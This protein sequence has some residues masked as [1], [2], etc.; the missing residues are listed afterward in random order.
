MKKYIIGGV[1]VI[2]GVIGAARLAAYAQSAAFS[3]GSGTSPVI[4]TISP[5]GDVL[6]RGT[7]ESVTADTLTI[8]SWGGVWTV[9]TS[10]VT[11]VI[12]PTNT[13]A[14][15]KV[16]D[17]AG[18]RGDMAHD[19]SFTIEAKTVRAWGHRTDSDKDGLPN[20]QDNDDDNDGKH[21]SDDLKPFDHDDDGI[22]DDQDSDDDNDLIDDDKDEDPLDHDND[23]IDDAQ[24]END[25]GADDSEDVADEADTD[26]D[27]ASSDS[28]DS[29][30]EE[31]SSESDN[32]GNSSGSGNSGS[33]NDSGS[34]D[35]DE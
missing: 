34:D 13:L 14:D 12:G 22:T 23:D 1:I 16:G 35:D 30:D 31:D 10:P 17:I 7:I 27:D 8:K 33:G 21:D 25:K 18:V 5:R 24:D 20:D 4:V 26:E 28:D 3:N 11:E 9:K 29:T 6:M 15:F 2:I 19:A 32:N